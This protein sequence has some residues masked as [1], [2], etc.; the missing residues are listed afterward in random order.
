MYKPATLP[1]S[2]LFSLPMDLLFLQKGVTKVKPD[3]NSV[4]VHPQLSHNR[5]PVD[6]VLV[7]VGSLRPLASGPLALEHL[8][9]RL[10]SIF[11]FPVF[12]WLFCIGPQ[13]GKLNFLCFLKREHFSLFF[14]SFFLGGRGAF[15]ELNWY[16]N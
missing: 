5:H 7:V 13:I 4:N 2:H 11:G 12:K 9:R 6:G 10:V 14:F 1:S 16:L 8:E 15:W 3:I